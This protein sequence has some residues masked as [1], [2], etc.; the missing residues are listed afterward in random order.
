MLDILKAHEI[1]LPSRFRLQ[2]YLRKITRL[3]PQH[4]DCCVNSCI[5]YTGQYSNLTACSHC[6]E[7]RYASDSYRSRKTFSFIPLIDRL[8]LQY[9]N[10]DRATILSTY[11]ANLTPSADGSMR[12][13][14]DGDLY[15]QFHVDQLKLF[16]DS[17]DVALQLSIDGVQ[18]TNKRNFEITPV[19]FINLNLPPD[20]RYKIENIMA[21]AIIPGPKKSK[22]IDSF[23]RPMIDELKMLH[24]GIDCYDAATNSHFT[25][26]AWITM[27][28]GDGPAIA[29]IMGFKRPGNAF[30]PCR[31]C[32]I[33]GTLGS[34]I[35]Y[36]PHTDYNFDRQP[37]RHENLREI[38]HLVAE[39]NSPQH[40]KQYGINRASILLELES[41]HFP[42]SFPIDIMHCILLNI[43]E[44]LWKL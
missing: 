40:C 25:L 27:T 5:A 1:H 31:H 30:R 7:S 29:D 15:R 17:R 10:S 39:A 32:L 12:D 19:I 18:V 41:L 44:T 9:S 2:S 35:Y 14:F 36:V 42:R 38:I 13:F 6:Q 28:T 16:Q 23:L 22:D 34:N 20:Q 11:R 26:H 37:L 3:R 24:D 8:K 33:T 21:S 43:T 4:L